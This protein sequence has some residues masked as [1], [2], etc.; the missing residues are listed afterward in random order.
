[1]ATFGD[2]STAAGLGQLNNHLKTR[3]YIEGYAMLGCPLWCGV[4]L[5]LVADI[6]SLMLTEQHSLSSV[7]FLMLDHSLTPSDGAFTLL[8][9]S[10]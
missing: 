2:L 10:E 3:S 1:M 5:R 6:P 9:L 7:D 4:N 8:L